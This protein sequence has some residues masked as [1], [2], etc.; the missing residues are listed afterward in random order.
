MA[1]VATRHKGEQV[2]VGALWVG[3]LGLSHA[4]PHVAQR[5]YLDAVAGGKTRRLVSDRSDAILSEFHHKESN[6][7][8]DVPLTR[9]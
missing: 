8:R 4:V 7:D 3:K 9:A 6:N 2:E 1:A 5:R